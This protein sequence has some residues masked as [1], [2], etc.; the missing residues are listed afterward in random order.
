MALSLFTMFSGAAIVLYDG[1]PFLPTCT[2]L[3]DLTDQLKISIFGTSPKWLQAC[4][5]KGMNP[6]MSLKV[7]TV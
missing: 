4:Q 5:E 1:S 2:N 7:F 3:W 6:G